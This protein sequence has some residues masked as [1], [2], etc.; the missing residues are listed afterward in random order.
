MIALKTCLA[1]VL[2]LAIALQLDWKPS[3][4]AILIVVL[5]TPMQGATYKKGLLYI[6]G[7]LSGAITGLTMVGLFV[8]DRVSFIVA[9][10]LVTGFGVYRM[11]GSRDAY[12]WLI[13]TVTSMLVGFFSVQDPSSAFSIAVMRSSTICLAVVIAFLV[14]GILWPIRAGKV[15][16]RQLH[17]FLD[18]CRGLVSL[19][20]RA[21]AGDAP[22]PDVIRKAE[23]AQIQAIAAIPGTLDAAT[24]DTE[25]FRKFQAA[26]QQLDS[27][28]YDLLLV[29]LAVHDGIASHHDGEPGKSEISESDN[30]RSKLEEVEGQMEELVRDLAL[31]RDGTAGPREVD[32]HAKAGIDQSAPIDTAFAAMLSASVCDLAKQVSKVRSTLAGVE[33]PLQAPA[34]L[35]AAPRTPFSLTGVKMRKAA[36][37]S[38]VILL[39]GW[40]FIQTQWPMGLMLSMVFASIAIC[41]GTL[42]PLVVIRRQLLRS[43]IIGPAIAAPLYFGIMPGIDQYGQ[44]I[45]WLCL[46]LFPLL[47]LIA[48]A[49]PK[50]TIQYLF[51]TIFVIALLSL[52]EES[53]S[54]SFSSFVNMW[55]GLCGGFVGALAVFGL[56]SSVVPEREF[57]KQVRG[58]FTGCGQTMQ[59]LVRSPPWTPAG[60]TVVKAQRQR[61]PGLFKQLQT[62]SA[63]IDY[64]RVPE[65]DRKATQA[66]VESIEHTALRLDAVE[67]ARR[68]PMGT[69]TESQREPLQRLYNACIEAFLLIASSVGDQ[70][71]VPALPDT[72]SLVRDLESRSEDFSLMN[73]SAR[74][75]SLADAIRDCRDK[76]N[77][78]DWEAWNRNYF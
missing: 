15:Y 74:L 42:I 28:L 32:I 37:S 23:T 51:S 29:I 54:Y 68:Q 49:N 45:P 50:T 12:A 17:D 60:A 71:P 78:L 14:H 47:Y 77:S 66:L 27:Q 70:K 64:D 48:S 55:I 53:Q 43:L 58:F 18:G 19:A 40:F 52:D 75:G 1:I 2:G 25:R 46:A 36:G 35:P 26:Y 72:G 3:F 63:A 38:L 57:W 33:D 34:P 4:G 41:L 10:A 30:I 24:A 9:L 8:H 39:L 67:H 44:L 6:A 76:A 11:Q 7:T 20:V 21:L 56:F 65:R 62:W 5:Q 16:E 13:F 59:S 31:P 69:L 61:W 22:D 73:E